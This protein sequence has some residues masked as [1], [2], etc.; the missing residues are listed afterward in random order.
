M[1]FVIIIVLVLLKLDCIILS[2]NNLILIVKLLYSFSFI[3]SSAADSSTF[4]AT[5][6]CF[7]LRAQI[8]PPPHIIFLIMGGGLLI[9]AHAGAL[10]LQGSNQI[11]FLTLQ[12][13]LYT[14]GPILTPFITL[15][16]KKTL[17]TRYF[18]VS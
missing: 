12:A 9:V 8:T 14:V 16:G 11:C 13:I 17:S 5:I 15:R 1:E 10:I 3:C 7:A 4:F 6:P 18:N 2:I